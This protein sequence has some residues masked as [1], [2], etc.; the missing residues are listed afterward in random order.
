MGVGEWLPVL[1]GLGMNL[2]GLA[3]MFGMDQR[4]RA[5]WENPPG[6]LGPG[7]TQPLPV[8]SGGDAALQQRFDEFG[9]EVPYGA[10]SL[11]QEERTAASREGMQERN[12][13]IESGITE[14]LDPLIEEARKRFETPA[15]SQNEVDMIVSQLRGNVN[16]TMGARAESAREGAGARGLSPDALQAIQQGMAADAGFQTHQG[17]LAAE[18]QQE[19]SNRAFEQ[20]RFD[21][22]MGLTNAY[23]ASLVP[24]QNLGLQLMEDPGGMGRIGAQGLASAFAEQGMSDQDAMMM[25]NMLMSMGQSSIDFGETRRMQNEMAA[26]AG[27]GSGMA[28]SMAGLG[29][30]TGVGLDLAMM[31]GLGAMNPMLLP[32]TLG[33]SALLGGGAG[34]GLGKLFGG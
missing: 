24:Q 18:L 27:G 3:R 12:V 10:F 25:A 5:F 15:V 4:H 33:G 11:A 26:A 9:R 30:T 23:N 6:A 31:G 20:Q 32:F 1:G 29:A 34:Y 2:A 28:G 7:E 22:L 21:D 16:R 8:L 17:Q 19:I 13:G 14:R